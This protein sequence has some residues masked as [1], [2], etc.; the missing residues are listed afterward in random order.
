MVNVTRCKNKLK[1]KV[2]KREMNETQLAE[3]PPV[4]KMTVFNMQ[5]KITV[6]PNMRCSLFID[7]IVSC[8]YYFRP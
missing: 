4:S 5:Y 1:I 6:D 2:Q 3:T 7:L 8:T